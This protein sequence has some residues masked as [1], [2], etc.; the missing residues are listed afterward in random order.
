[1]AHDITIQIKKTF[2]VTNAEFILIRDLASKNSR[3]PTIK[4][5]KAQYELG[6]YEAKTLV[7]TIVDLP[8]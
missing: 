3:I 5:I 7:D 1:M 2:T 4:F 6:L 8:F